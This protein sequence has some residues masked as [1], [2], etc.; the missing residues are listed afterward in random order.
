MKQITITVSTF[1]F[2]VLLTVIAAHA[3]STPAFRPTLDAHLAAISGRNMDALLPTITEGKDLPMISP[4]GYKFDTRQQFVD[5][6]RQWFATDDKGKLDFEVVQVIETPKLAHALVKYRYSSM[7]KD[8][9]TQA[10]DNWLALT[11][12]LEKDRWRLVF[13]QNTPINPAK[14]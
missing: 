3:Q 10:N 13:D 8:G 6:H 2:A 7:G 12:A 14:N 11:F 4:S 9:K 1:L 5:F